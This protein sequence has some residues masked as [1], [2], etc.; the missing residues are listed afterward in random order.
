MCLDNFSGS[1]IRAEVGCFPYTI[2]GFL[3]GRWCIS[4]NV[5][6]FGLDYPPDNGDDYDILIFALIPFCE[7]GVC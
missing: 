3:V 2:I 7:V 1:V 6:F 5:L 4:C